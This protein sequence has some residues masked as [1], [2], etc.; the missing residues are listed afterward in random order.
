MFLSLLMI[1]ACTAGDD[2]AADVDSTIAFLSPDD[3]ATVAIGDVDFSVVV[4]NFG[5]VDLAK[6]GE[7]ATPE[8][9]IGVSVGGVEVLQT[10]DT[11]FTLTLDAAGTVTVE[12]ELFHGDDGD[13]LDERA[14]A[15][16]SLTV[17]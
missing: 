2:T 4:E 10:S 13:P 15:S 11:Q 5:L 9:Y 16:L 8:G 3:G 6:H 14:V 12:A 1:L 7:E 17:E